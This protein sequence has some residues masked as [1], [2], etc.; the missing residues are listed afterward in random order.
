[1]GIIAGCEKLCTTA[2]EKMLIDADWLN[3]D[4]DTADDTNSRVFPRI[5]AKNLNFAAENLKFVKY[6][7]AE[8]ALELFESKNLVTVCAPM[9]RYSK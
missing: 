6:F 8:M 5:S 7:I 9:V 2:F 3:G 4:T 1:M